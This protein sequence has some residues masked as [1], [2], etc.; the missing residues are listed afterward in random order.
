MGTFSRLRLL[1]SFWSCSC[2]CDDKST[3]KQ[4]ITYIRQNAACPRD[5]KQHSVRTTSCAI[6]YVIIS[7]QRM[8]MPTLATAA[9]NTVIVFEPMHNHEYHILEQDV[10]TKDTRSAAYRRCL[11]RF[12]ILSQTLM[13]LYESACCDM[14]LVYLTELIGKYFVYVSTPP[15]ATLCP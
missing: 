4:Q 6:F 9:G 10:A 11:R 12:Y 5:I 3:T 14:L 13:Q 1:E 15:Y 2:S 7:H 8:H